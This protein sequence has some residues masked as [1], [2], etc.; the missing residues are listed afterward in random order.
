MTVFGA[1]LLRSDGTSLN[2]KY[3]YD[4]S[5]AWNKVPGNGAYV[6]V[7]DGLTA[8]G[9]G[10][11]LAWL[12][13]EEEVA[14][15]EVPTGVKCFRRVRVLDKFPEGAAPE[16]Y[17]EIA[18]C[19]LGLSAEQRIDLALEST[20]EWRGR[21]AYWAPGLNAKQRVEL[22]LKST[23]KW[24]GEV[25]CYAPGLS[26]EQRV[27]LA[28]K[29]TPEWRGKVACYTPGLSA[30]QRMDLALESSPNWRNRAACWADGLSAKQRKKL[31]QTGD[32][33]YD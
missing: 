12:E 32:L 13:C 16:L 20:P 5:G 14:G 22:A 28:L 6:A 7:T 8:G 17:C 18:C 1:K 24:R 30:E 33:N 3:K 23:P 9:N 31:R 26:A 11:L 15:T 4:L 29:S 25:A 27:E 21:A 10:P 19:M 2:G